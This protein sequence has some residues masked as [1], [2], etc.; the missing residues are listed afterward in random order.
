MKLT[1]KAGGV[2]GG[3][4]G[5]PLQY[6]AKLVGAEQKSG[7]NGKPGLLWQ[8]EVVSG[9]FAKSKAAG[10]TDLEPTAANKTG[11]FLAGITGKPLVVE[12][13]I[14]LQAFVGKTYLIG[15]EMTDK[16]GSKVVSVSAPP[17]A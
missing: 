8:F 13:E 14:D 3:S 4:K 5:S 9:P 12:Q 15:V 6:V 17:T 1:V 11:R 16:G 2:P 7:F 10:M